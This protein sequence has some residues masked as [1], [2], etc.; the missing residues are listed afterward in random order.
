MV[1]IM[2]LLRPA[3]RSGRKIASVYLAPVRRATGLVMRSRLLISGEPAKPIWPSV[4]RSR[5]LRQ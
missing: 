2:G 4:S 1:P 5:I 3:I